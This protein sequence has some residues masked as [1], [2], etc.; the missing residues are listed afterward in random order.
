MAPKV[1][2]V[3]P[4][5]KLAHLLSE[6]VNSILSQTY[7][8]LEVIIMDDCSPDGTSQTVKSFRDSPRKIHSER[9]QSWPP[10]Q[11]QRGNWPLRRR[12][13]MANLRG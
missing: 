12:I 5:Y 3:V 4:C 2:F 9:N 10:A 1:S 8:N 6:C 11:L 13:Y 7:E